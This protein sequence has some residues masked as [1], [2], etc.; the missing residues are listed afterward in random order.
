MQFI[1]NDVQMFLMM[2]VQHDRMRVIAP[3]ADYSQL[4]REHLDAIMISNYHRA[5]DARYAMSNGILYAAYIHPLSELS[6]VQVEYSVEQVAN[7][8]KTF[9]TAYTSACWTL[10]VSKAQSKNAISMSLFQRL[11]NGL[12]NDSKRVIPALN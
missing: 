10:V 1:Y 2:D 9:G 3:V 6:R 12:A 7:L 4:S 11:P 8:A 5:L